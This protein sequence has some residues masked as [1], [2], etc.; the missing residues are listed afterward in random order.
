MTPLARLAPR[1]LLGA[2]LFGCG[3]EANDA[4]QTSA[5]GASGASSTARA[6]G[7]GA[8]ASGA[9]GA[10][11]PTNN[12][13]AGVGSTSAN[14]GI[15]GTSSAQAG[16]VTAA[17]QG[18]GGLNSG[19]SNAGAGGSLPT[20]LGLAPITDRTLD[21]DESVVVPLVITGDDA[22]APLHLSA[23]GLP[24]GATLD[25]AA[26]AIRFRPDFLQ[27]GGP[28]F[29]IT[30]SARRGA[31]L[32]ETS[33]TITIVDTIV[34]PLPTITKTT[35]AGSCQRLAVAQ[36]T[37][38]YLDS[39][40]RAGR[41]FDATVL[42][43]KKASDTSRLPVSVQLH[44]AGTPNVPQGVCDANV[45]R[46]YPHDPKDTY[47]WGFS[48]N[49]PA[50]QATSGLVKPYTARRVLALLGWALATQHGDPARV[51]MAGSS[52][53][54][55][56]AMTIGLLWGRHF[57]S[58]EAE[59]GQ[60]I[61]KNHRPARLAQLEGLWGKPA[62]GLLDE[63][64]LPVWDRMDLTRALRD[65][66]EASGPFLF[67]RHGK[68][69]KTIHFGA[70]VE[71]SALTG[72]SFYDA[73]ATHP[74][75]A[76]W[77]EGGHGPSDPVLGDDWWGSGFRALTDA[78][79][80]ARA[81]GSLPAFSAS[82][83][84]GDPGDG[85]GNGKTTYTESGGYAGDE[86]VAGDTGW[87]GDIAGAKNRHLRWDATKLVDTPE[88]WS[89]PVRIF[90]GTGSAPPKAGYPTKG[91]RVAGALPASVT[92]SV[93]HPQ[94]FTTRANETVAWSFGDTKGTVTT[95]ARGLV[96]VPALA[97]GTT[98]TTL[99]IARLDAPSP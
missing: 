88:E 32:A 52:M 99:R 63:L 89:V 64:G 19:G 3:D 29:A 20:P 71:K 15:G 42:V 25:V 10:G 90:E 72:Q 60:A 78:T 39:P 45:I 80:F 62:L 94:R 5:A 95:D 38:V 65:D 93:R 6:G 74:H 26:R 75:L 55:A 77:D 17:G 40:G 56:G 83:L 53:G 46:I 2:A 54:G 16:S 21:E 41:T 87:S 13:G 76:I 44:G 27:G 82:S 81:N 66:P 48:E 35:D 73:L 30:V 58:I 92:I 84:D 14:G 31:E 7:A 50:G 86:A 49:L 61:P 11:G 97:L 9:A 24:P 33:F 37:D 1:L 70:V 8:G 23:D 68:D 47:W 36:K 91:D 43:P 34:P 96:T 98:W 79:S 69:D 57:A 12:G 22:D 67:L 51:R 4:V 28:P 59:L 85:S 18:G